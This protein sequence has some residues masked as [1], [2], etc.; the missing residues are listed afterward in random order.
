VGSR[1]ETERYENF[2][3]AACLSGHRESQMHGLGAKIRDVQLGLVEVWEDRAQSNRLS[4][5]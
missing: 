3:D 1:A 4:V 5:K 2:I